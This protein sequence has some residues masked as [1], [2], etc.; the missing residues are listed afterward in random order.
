MIAEYLKISSFLVVCFMIY[1]VIPNLFI[2]V[3]LGILKIFTGFSVKYN[4]ISK[5]YTSLIIY[6]EKIYACIIYIVDLLLN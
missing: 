4:A 5:T 1:N 3:K 2:F 6:T